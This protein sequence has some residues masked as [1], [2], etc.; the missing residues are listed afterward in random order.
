[1]EFV[2]YVERQESFILAGFVE[3]MFAMSTLILQQGYA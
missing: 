1:M 2:Q 3:K